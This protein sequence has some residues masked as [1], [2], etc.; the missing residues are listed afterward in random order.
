MLSRRLFLMLVGPA[1][2]L[3]LG[4][5][6]ASGRPAPD[7]DAVVADPAPAK[8]VIA[9]TLTAPQNGLIELRV[10]NLDAK[11]MV[12]WIIDPEPVGIREIGNEVVFCGASGDYRV[13]A[14]IV[15]V[16]GAGKLDKATLRATAKIDG[17]KPPPP[18]PD[19]PPGPVDPPAT[20]LTAAFQTAYNSVVENA[21]IRQVYLG[22]LIFMYDDAIRDAIPDKA[23][24]TWKDFHDRMETAR[25]AL[26]P[27]DK[28]VVFIAVRK[29]VQKELEKTFPLGNAASAPF[30]DAARK[31][32]AAAFARI[33]AALKGVKP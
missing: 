13:R 26:I 2:L 29:A 1:L 15:M 10:D 16:D 22:R 31:N 5:F 30:D 25:Q 6:P 12:L 14:L 27:G 23:L 32:A 33:V 8:P 7:V 20:D 4:A 19:P 11:A 28:Q 18:P 24:V 21:T 9:G 17:V 3:M